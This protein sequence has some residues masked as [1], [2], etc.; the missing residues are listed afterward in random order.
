[1]NEMYVEML[2]PILPPAE[3][4]IHLVVEILLMVLICSSNIMVLVSMSVHKCLHTVTNMFLVSLAIA[5]LLMGLFGCPLDIIILYIMPLHLGR[6]I[7]DKWLCAARLF[8]HNVSAGASVYSM[9]G[10]AIDRFIAVKYPLRYRELITHTRVGI[11]IGCIWVYIIIGSSVNFLGDI[12]K[13]GPGD[14]CR[15]VQVRD[16][17]FVLFV[18]CNILVTFL[19]STFAHIVVAIVA[20]HQRAKVASE[21]AAFNNN[22]AVAYKKENRITKTMSLIVGLF[23]LCWL[24]YI[25]IT[26]VKFKGSEPKWFKH[27]FSFTVEISIAN[28]LINPWIYAF[29]L[30]LWRKAMKNVLFC[31]YNA[32]VSDD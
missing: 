30:K 24:P 19:V 18:K 7:Q 5:D 2:K 12:V 27:L 22:L 6:H 16:P 17:N 3:L 31:K 21:L 10:I 11:F 29:R 8:C 9:V 20:T 32:H 15:S 25:L 13:F 14:T 4:S 1:M 23:V 28:S 26:M